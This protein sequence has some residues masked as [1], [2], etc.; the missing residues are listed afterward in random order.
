M[1]LFIAVCYIWNTE[2][3]SRNLSVVSIERIILLPDSLDIFI[4]FVLVNG[5]YRMRNYL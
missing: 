4:S 2:N 3:D 5:F 1:C